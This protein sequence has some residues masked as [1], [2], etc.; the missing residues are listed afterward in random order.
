MVMT[1]ETGVL[2]GKPVSMPLLLPQIPH[3][4]A[5]ARTWALLAKVG[6]ELP[7]PWQRNE[8]DAKIIF[9]SVI[10]LYSY[11]TNISAMKN[12]IHLNYMQQEGQFK[13]SVTLRRV[14]A[15]ILVVE[16]Q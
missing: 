16:K 9:M 8:E 10:Q 6:D 14:R 4:Q 13:Y 2:G 1:G 7:E 3:G 11:G 15:T 5:L 12:D